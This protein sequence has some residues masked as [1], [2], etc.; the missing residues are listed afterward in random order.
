MSAPSADTAS[1]SMRLLLDTADRQEWERLLPVFPFSGVTTNPTLLRRVGLPCDLRTIEDLARAAFDLGAEEM[2]AQAW[3][4]TAEAFLRTGEAIA[5]LDKRMVVK[6]PATAAGVT[7]ARRLIRNGAKVTLTAVYHPHQVLT[8]VALGCAYAAPY[9]GRMGDAGLAAADDIAAMTAV[10]RGT[11][12]RVLVASLR[13]PA[14]LGLLAARG[15]DTFTMSP[16][17]ADAMLTEPLTL[18]AAEN[19]ETDAAKLHA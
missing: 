11:A 17:T 12:T 1:R 13:L 3:G 2:Q 19:F 15:A 9:Y 18:E 7:V 14:D 16:A 6:L 10:A 4:G 5:A 8:A